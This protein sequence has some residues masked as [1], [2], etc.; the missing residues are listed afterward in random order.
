[1]TSKIKV[2]QI[3]GQS[4]TSIE[5]P[6]GHTFKVTDLGNNKVLSTNSSGVV[7]A[8]AMGS[9]DQV[10]KMTGT[11]TLGFGAAGGGKMLQVVQST[12][13]TNYTTTSSSFVYV[14]GMPQLNITPS[15]TTSKILLLAHC[16]GTEM[17]GGNGYMTIYRD[18]TNLGASTHGFANVQHASNRREFGASF[19]F[20]DEPST[21]S[22]ITYNIRMANSA[23]STISFSESSKTALIAIEVGA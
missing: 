8:V 6:T 7:T 11:N 12:S 22:Q 15:A 5:V 4:G 2:D 21:T 23:G 16:G 17:N 20:L 13:S 3:E 10:L 9:T 19:N 1:M 18:S 14:S